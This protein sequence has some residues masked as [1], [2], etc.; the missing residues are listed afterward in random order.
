MRIQLLIMSHLPWINSNPFQSR[1]YLSVPFEGK[2]V[3]SDS[4]EFAHPDIAMGLTI[5]SYRFVCLCMYVRVGHPNISFLF[6]F[7]LFYFI[8]SQ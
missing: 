2:D 8:L 1:Q 3:P 4:S 6:Y 5:L 7:I